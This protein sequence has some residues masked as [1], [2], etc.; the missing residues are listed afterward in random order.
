MRKLLLAGVLAFLFACPAA[1]AEEAEAVAISVWVEEGKNLDALTDVSYDTMKRFAPQ[2]VLHIAPQDAGQK[3]YGLY[4][5]WAEP[6]QRWY[7]HWGGVTTE[8]GR[9]GFLHEYV[10]L[11]EGT[12]GV[13]LTLPGGEK[14]CDVLAYSA[15]PLPADVQ[16]W[17]PPCDRADLLLFPAHADDEI[18]FFGGVLAEYAGERG[19]NTQVAYFSRYDN[20]RE[21]EKL[22]GLW[23]C[24]VRNYP[25][26]AGFT[27]VMPG[28]QAE[29]RELFPEEDALEF[30]V[31]QLRRFR[32]QICIA[33]DVDGEYGHETHKYTAAMVRR[34][35]EISGDPFQ[36]PTSAAA[37][38]IWDVP[39]AYLH[40]WEENPVRLNCRK[41]LSRFGGRTALEV[42][43]EAYTMHVSQ[44]WCWFYVSDDYEYSIADFGLY[45]STVGADTGNDL[46]EHLTPYARQPRPRR[47]EPV[48]VSV[49][50]WA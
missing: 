41:P 40:L 29:A 11:E 49:F 30:Y 36:F 22:D 12:D 32:P 37:F 25:I 27:D 33:H 21:H 47:K 43:A 24:G 50:P 42:A 7:L 48:H 31:E 8:H 5:R 4:L 39:K 20:V 18:L 10:P 28:S 38:G 16:V 35:L 6:P 3:L 2:T 17:Q 44:Q 13:S 23:T 46:M 19:L 26:S 34:A 9:N 15:G 1:A 14:L 45:R